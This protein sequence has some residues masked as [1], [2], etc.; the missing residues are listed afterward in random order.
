MESV[1]EEWLV[2]QTPEVQAVLRILLNR[3]AE[4]EAKLGKDSSNSSK[5][6]STQHP[7]AK[8]SKQAQKKAKRKSGGQPGHPKHERSLV[9]AHECDGVIVCL[10]AEC[11]RC[12]EPLNGT[13]PQP[14]RHQ[15]WEIPEIKPS[16]TEYQLHRLR[17]SCGKTTCGELPPGVPVG[18]AGP[19]LVALSALLMVCFRLS[20]RRCALFLEQILGQE[21]SASWMIKLQN[22]AAEALQAPYQELALALPGEAVLNGDESPTKEGLAKAWTWTFVAATFSVFALRTSRKAQ[23]VLEFLGDSF[24]GVLGCDRAKMYWAFGRLQWCWAHLLRDFQSLIDRP[25]PV[26]RRLGH[27]LQRQTRAMFEL[28]NRVRDGTL[29]HKA[30]GEQMIPIRSEVE[31]LLLRGKFDPKLRG[32][33]S[34]LWKYRARLWTFVDVEG[35]EPTNNAAERALRPA[36]IWRKLCFGTQSAQGS[37]FV[38]RMLTAIETCRQ[39]KRNSF[40]W[41][42]QAVQAHFAQEKAPSLLARA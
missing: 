15:V 40:A 24:T 7:H 21:A 28:W 36:V 1:S 27:D 5:P 17:C 25:C 34:E 9:S 10:P 23:V 4:L 42:T 2:R 32:F 35:V 33:C 39:Q 8:L 26:A 41:M 14:L 3:I 22:R 29:S 6:P 37:R 20:K 19:R 31:A 38:E 16:I 12:G 30:F 13:D 18:M 11:R